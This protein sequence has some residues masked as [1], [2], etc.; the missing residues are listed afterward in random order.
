MTRR[1]FIEM[2]LRQIYGDQPSD[3][4]NITYN[5]VNVWLEQAIGLAAKQNYKDNI[6]IEGIG[7][8]NNSF[9]TKFTGLT[10]TWIVFRL[11]PPQEVH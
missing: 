11:V 10:I 5:L 4:A 9:Y 8:L 6:S 1:K 3:D 2:V 7:F